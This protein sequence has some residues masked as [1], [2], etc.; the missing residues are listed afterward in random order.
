LPKDTKQLLANYQDVPQNLMQ[1]IVH[2]NSTRKDFI[3]QDIL[4]H[5][6]KVVGI[7]R[8]IMKAGSDN[9]RAS[10]IQGIMKRL[11][12]KGIEVIVYEPILGQKE[13]F[14]SRVFD[15]LTEFKKYAELIVSNR[16]VD[17]LNDVAYKVYT[18]DLFG[19]D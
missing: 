13:F 9:W 19:G 7:Y 5:K 12:A 14:N 16:M 3:A 17:E 8:L 10:S 11:K 6:P 2:S 15:E 18:R 1:A 4:A